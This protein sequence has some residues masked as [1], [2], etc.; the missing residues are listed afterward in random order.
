MSQPLRE[1]KKKGEM[2]LYTPTLIT[3]ERRK[4]ELQSNIER[5]S[6]FLL[7]VCDFLYFVL[8]QQKKNC[9]NFQSDFCLNLELKVSQNV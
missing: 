3:N 5:I 4:R 1:R 9:K 2:I 7:F 8:K 6:H